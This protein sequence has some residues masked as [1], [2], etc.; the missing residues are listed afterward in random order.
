M[1]LICFELEITYKAE[2]KMTFARH[3]NAGG[4]GAYFFYSC[5]HFN[6]QHWKEVSAECDVPSALTPS[7]PPCHISVDRQPRRATTSAWRL[8]KKERS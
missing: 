8:W 3:L 1:L 5:A 4:G 2:V 6:I 7:T